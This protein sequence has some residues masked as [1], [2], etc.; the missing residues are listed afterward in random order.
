MKSYLQWLGLQIIVIVVMLL[1]P[2]AA[3]WLYA[4]DDDFRR[5]VHADPD[6]LGTFAELYREY[7]ATMKRGHL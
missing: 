2:F 4:T 7:W 6:L 3:L 1:S 5:D